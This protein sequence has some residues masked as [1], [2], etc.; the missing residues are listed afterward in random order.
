MRLGRRSRAHAIT[1]TRRAIRRLRLHTRNG[2]TL[3]L[4]H[5]T[6]S[7]NW[8]VQEAHSSGRNTRRDPPSARTHT[9]FT[10][11][12][13]IGVDG[14]IPT[15]EFFRGLEVRARVVVGGGPRPP[16]R[17]VVVTC[18]QGEGGGGQGRVDSP[19]LEIVPV[20]YVVAA[21]VVSKKARRL[22]DPCVDHLGWGPHARGVGE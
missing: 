4:H 15:V 10:N 19:L 6:K 18:G 22:I 5:T 21:L 14:E 12:A 7:L 17:V 2:R 13:S 16:P 3:H 20:G 1:S 11:L 8:R 9:G